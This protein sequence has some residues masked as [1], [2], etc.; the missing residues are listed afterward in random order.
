MFNDVYMKKTTKRQ[1]VWY[2]SCLVPTI[3]FRFVAF[4]LLSLCWCLHCWFICVCVKAADG[5]TLGPPIIFTFVAVAFILLLWWCHH[6][7]VCLFVCLYF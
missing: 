1:I 7:I 5:I 2:Y 6:F 4:M 3:I